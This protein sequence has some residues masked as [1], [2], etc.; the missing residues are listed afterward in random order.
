MRHPGV[1]RLRIAR[2]QHP[3]H[4]HRPRRRLRVE[5]PAALRG[6]DRHDRVG[7]PVGEEE[8][9]I[10]G[11]FPHGDV[12][13]RGEGNVV[14]EGGGDG[15]AGGGGGG[16]VAGGEGGGVFVGEGD[17]GGEGVGPGLDHVSEGEVFHGLGGAVEEVD[18]GVAGDAVRGDA[19]R[20]GLLCVLVG[21]DDRGA[22]VEERA[23][24]FPAVGGGDAVGLAEGGAGVGGGRGREARA[25]ELRRAAG[26]AGRVGAALADVALGVVAALGE[27]VADLDGGALRREERGED[28]ESE[29]EG[30]EVGGLHER[31]GC[32]GQGFRRT[33]E[34]CERKGVARTLDFT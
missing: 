34:G 3:V 9:V 4:H 7:G 17:D 18:E 28:E 30:E 27:V 19:P 29:G 1:H 20:A 5:R 13:A 33:G 12:A 11:E 32:G 16:E 31:G 8:E 10:D 22:V 21:L 2:H 14:A 25:V 24:V 6:A 23:L 26:A 15:G